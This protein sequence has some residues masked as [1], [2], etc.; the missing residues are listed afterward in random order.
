M[1]ITPIADQSRFRHE[2]HKREHDEHDDG[3][4]HGEQEV[5]YEHDEHEHDD[6]HVE[7]ADG[8]EQP[9]ARRRP[10]ALPRGQPHRWPRR[11]SLLEGATTTSRGAGSGRICN[12]GFGGGAC[13]TGTGLP[14]KI[15]PPGRHTANDPIGMLLGCLCA[16]R[17]CAGG[18]GGMQGLCGLVCN[19][20][21]LHRTAVRRSL[22]V[23]NAGGG[24]T[25]GGHVERGHVSVWSTLDRR[26]FDR[27]KRL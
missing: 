8:H 25:N 1:R 24:G 16:P 22:S 26:A 10:R 12:C 7:H 14:I 6:G 17:W 18:A 15:W 23:Y 19:A 4:E 11:P 2:G 13:G 21:L 9:R 3:H 20:W 5:G 27:G